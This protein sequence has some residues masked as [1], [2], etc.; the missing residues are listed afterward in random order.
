[1]PVDS[2]QSSTLTQLRGILGIYLKSNLETKQSTCAC[3]VLNI[4]KKLSFMSGRVRYVKTLWVTCNLISDKNVCEEDPPNFFTFLS[5]YKALSS[6]YEANSSRD[7]QQ[8]CRMRYFLLEV[9]LENLGGAQNYHFHRC[10][11]SETLVCVR[12]GIECQKIK[13]PKCFLFACNIVELFELLP[14]CKKEQWLESIVW[15]VSSTQLQ[16]NTFLFY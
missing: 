5:S 7:T 13:C 1:M 15:D 4:R 6:C 14:G 2:V 16:I 12:N 9:Y 3:L 10:R 8:L 11:L